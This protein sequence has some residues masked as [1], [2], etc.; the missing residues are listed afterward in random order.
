MEFIYVVTLNGTA[1]DA[2][3]AIDSLDMI[4]EQEMAILLGHVV[5]LKAQ[6]NAPFQ[7]TNII[8]IIYQFHFIIFCNLF[9]S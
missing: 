5:T 1:I 3:T 8:E 6:R 9:T 4:T 2:Q 7:Y